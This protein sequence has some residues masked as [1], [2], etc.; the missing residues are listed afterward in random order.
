MKYLVVL[1]LV[2]ALSSALITVPIRK[3]QENTLQK[4]LRVNSLKGNIQALLNKL[5]PSNMVSSWPEVK[6]NN[7][8]D[9][10]YFGEV[11]IGTPAQTFTVIFDTGSSNLWVPSSECGLLSVACQLHKKYNAK[12]SKTYQKNGTEFSIKY[13]S[14]SVAGHWSEDTVSLAGLEAT[15]VLF[16]EATTL[17]GVSFLASKFDGILGMAFSAISID[18]IPPVFQVL[19]T[20]GKVSDGSFSFFLTDKAGEEGSALVLGGV[21]PQ[22]AA[23]DFKYYPVT[24]E[25]WWVIA[26]SKVT[27]GNKTYQLTNSIVDTGTSVLVGPKAIVSDMVKSLP[28]KGAQAVDCSTIS[29]F[30]NLTFTIGGDDYVLAPTDY[31]LQVTAQGQTECVLGIQGMDLPSPIDNAFILGDSFIHKF[32]THFDMANKRVGFALAKHD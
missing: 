1:A 20:E 13:G 2:L 26:V 6:I 14:G 5:F 32:Y 19:M 29:K 16:G 27:L 11:S 31:I 24:L 8:M 10:Q 3:P 4:L 22:F 23:S 7:Y 30:P 28:N 25:A 21:D 17:N 9:A 12:K 15:G 18:H